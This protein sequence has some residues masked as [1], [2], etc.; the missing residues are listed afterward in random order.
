ME[1][2]ILEQLSEL[3]KIEML[4]RAVQSANSGIK[5]L[6]KNAQ[7]HI[8]STPAPMY[9]HYCSELK[10]EDGSLKGYIFFEDASC[11]NIG[12]YGRLLLMANYMNIT[13]KSPPVRIFLIVDSRKQG[14]MIH[15]EVCKRGNIPSELLLFINRGDIYE[16]VE[17]WNGRIYRF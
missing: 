13:Q 9:A 10:N 3:T 14:L 17:G 11:G 1:A 5:R 12:A 2:L 6:I 4:V 16:N 15:E 7:I 8:V